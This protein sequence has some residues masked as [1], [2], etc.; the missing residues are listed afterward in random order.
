[1]NEGGRFR[2]KDIVSSFFLFFFFMVESGSKVFCTK[3]KE[4]ARNKRNYERSVCNRVGS[5]DPQRTKGN[6]SSIA[7]KEFLVHLKKMVY[8]Y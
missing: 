1:M 2:T 6:K 4:K 7:C 8:T 5:I 3:E